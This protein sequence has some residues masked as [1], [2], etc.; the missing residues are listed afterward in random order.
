M[1]GLT[2]DDLDLTMQSLDEA[3][4]RQRMEQRLSDPDAELVCLGPEERGRHDAVKNG[5]IIAYTPV[6]RRERQLRQ[7]RRE[8]A[9]CALA[10]DAMA[11]TGLGSSALG[12]E[13]DIGQVLARQQQV[14][15]L[16][17]GVEPTGVG[18][19]GAT[20]LFVGL[21]SVGLTLYIWQEMNSAEQRRIEALGRQ[22]ADLSR[23]TDT[24][25]GDL[26][27]IRDLQGRFPDGSFD[28]AYITLRIRNGEGPAL[29]D[30]A[31]EAADADFLV[32]AE[33]AVEAA[34]DSAQEARDTARRAVEAAIEV[35]CNDDDSCRPAPEAFCDGD[36][37]CLERA[38]EE[39]FRPA[40][41]LIAECIQQT[42]FSPLNAPP[43]AECR[44]SAYTSFRE[45]SAWDA[46]VLGRT[47]PFPMC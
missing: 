13:A 11:E 16:V 3:A 36:I 39:S 12:V 32:E 7:M 14:I 37:A 33:D 20:S 34:R 30:E 44:A 1:T 22:A 46:S 15:D 47:S 10:A 9:S 41:L 28:D 6:E 31:L 23:L 40:E 24:L 4:Y 2:A 45:R 19:V 38:V 26:A 8:G 18:A 35:Q 43:L 42:G 29:S 25:S 27:T 5:S 17:D 21:I